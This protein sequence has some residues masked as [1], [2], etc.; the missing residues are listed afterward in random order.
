MP[1]KTL[2]SLIALLALSV[3]L[4]A[5]APSI[6]SQVSTAAKAGDFTAAQSILRAYR[7][8][9]GASAAYLEAFSW[10]GR[11]KLMAKQYPDA[12]ANAAEVRRL[13]LAL[14]K[15]RKLDADKN[16]PIALGASIEV[17][18]QAL[19]ATGR[20]TEAVS[21]L[22]TEADRWKDTSIA[23]RIHKNLNLISLEGKPAPE[24]ETALGIGSVRPRPLTAHKGHP[25]LL[26]FWAHWCT[27]CRAEA[28]ILD[29]LKREFPTVS[30]LGPTQHY[31]YISKGTATSDAQETAYIEL[32]RRQFYANL[33][34]APAVVNEENFASWGVS[35][36]PTLVLIDKAGKVAQYHPG[37]MSE[38]EL[39]AALT[40]LTH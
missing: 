25:V 3:L 5:D 8:K 15:S 34:P 23:A 40:R 19:A 27:D 2:S 14:L 29:K 13:S 33:V 10:V 30:F 28:P 35:T 16:L 1:R 11:G 22:T 7:Q 38:A 12:L 17:E 39:R 20:L 18:G 9:Y 4:I 32:V 26:F 36:T 21:F 24:L 31:G 6:T 37:N